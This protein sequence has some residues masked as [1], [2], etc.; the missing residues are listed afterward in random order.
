M[1]RSLRRIK[2]AYHG[3]VSSPKLGRQKYLVALRLEDRGNLAS[4][5]PEAGYLNQHVHNRLGG[6]SRNGGAAEVLNAQD[7]CRRHR[8]AQMVRLAPEQLWPTWIVRHNAD[9]LAHGSLHALLVGRHFT[10]T[11][12]ILS[13]M[14]VFGPP[15][16]PAPLYFYPLWAAPASPVPSKSTILQRGGLCS[17][18]ILRLNGISPP[19][20]FC[21]LFSSFQRFCKY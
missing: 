18:S 16:A 14:V 5:C 7:E 19:S 3:G 15:S 17:D 2:N 6:Q 21:F 8:G 20:H 13:F 12:G 11:V 9:V 10:K 4:G 1:P